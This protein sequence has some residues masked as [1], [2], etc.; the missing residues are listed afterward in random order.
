MEPGWRAGR[1]GE[2]AAAVGEA[3]AL[4]P[5]TTVLLTVG[6]GIGGAVVCDGRLVPGEGAAGDFG[7]MTMDVHGPPYV[8][9]GRGCLEQLVSG[10]A[11]DD[12]ARTLGL[13]HAGE[14]DEAARAVPGLGAGPGRL[15]VRWRR[16]RRCWRPG[17][18]RSPRRRI[19]G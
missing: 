1:R 9:G 14:L 8:C 13:R 6:T 12:L 15:G 19:P 5:G 11:L 2:Q 4:G 18:A 10:R 7:H 3:D 16:R 17:C